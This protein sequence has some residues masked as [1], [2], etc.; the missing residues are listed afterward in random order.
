MPNARVQ[1]A[2]DEA[3]RRALYRSRSR[4][5]EMLYRRTYHGSPPPDS[6][7]L[8]A[9]AKRES[10]EQGESFQRALTDHATAT[11]AAQLR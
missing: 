1:R 10:P 8:E 4:C 9:R 6:Y 3:E 2:D 11:A 5:N 7:C